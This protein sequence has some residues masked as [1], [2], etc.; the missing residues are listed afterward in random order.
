MPIQPLP[1]HKLRYI[2][3][4]AQFAFETTAELSPTS[5]IIGQPRGIRAIEFGIGIQSEGYNIY[6]LGPSG[7]GRATAIERFLRERSTQQPT[8]LDWVYV[9]NFTIP[10]QPRA[11]ELIAGE[12]AVFK[13]RM[14]QLIKNLREVL[15]QAFETEA[16]EKT[17][18]SLS[19]EIQ[20][21]QRELLD[22]LH[23]EALPHNFG[24]VQTASGFVMAPV[25]DG[26][27]LNSEEI[28]ELPLD[29]QHSID[30][31]AQDWQL[32]LNDILYQVHV[33]EEDGRQQIKE[34][35]RQVAEN[36]IQHYF[37]ELRT[38]YAEREEIL[39]YLG[40]VY[41]DVLN[42]IDDFAPA[43][44]SENPD[45]EIDLRRYEVN[46]LV[47]HSTSKGAPVVTEQ[48]PTYYNLIGRIEY[49]M[50]DSIVSTHFTNIKAGSLHRANGGYL[51]MNAQDLMRDTA[52][53]ETLKRALR[54]HEIRVQPSASMDGEQVLAKS[55][56]PEPIPL[57]IKIILTG[58]ASLYY[59]LYEQEEDFCDLFK[60][61]ADFDS[62]MNRDDQHIQE[63]AQFIATRCH[64]EKLRHF[65][66]AA[67]AKIVEFG[68]FMVAYQKKLT[69]RFGSIADLTREASYWAGVNGRSLVTAGDVQQAINERTY[70]AN[71]LEERI[72]EQILEGSVF[73]ATDGRVVGQVNGL[74]VIDLGDYYFGQ[75]G[76]VTART[77]MGD[78]GVVHIER[79]TE[80]SGPI[81]EKGVLTLTGYLGGKY[82]QHQ[83]L[84]LTASVTFEQNYVPVEGDSA[85]TTELYAL[86]S[87]L[88]GIPIKQ[89]IGVTG[90]VNQR[91]EVQPIGGVNEK[92]LGFFKVC[93]ARGLTG[94]QG[95]MIPASNIDNLMLEEEILAACAEGKFHV[96]AIAT[97]DEGLELLMDVPAGQMDEEGQYPEGTVHYSVQQRLWQLAK[98]LNDFGNEN[99][100]GNSEESE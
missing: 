22:T 74:T 95:V 33:L 90:S 13:S 18:E 91:G 66:R 53:W 42:Q 38:V 41:Q 78:D 71:S 68:S 27:P 93:Q 57:N 81:H 58:S 63:Y 79:E 2:C 24:L 70:R 1:P 26:R 73:I 50:I 19:K 82:A 4:P 64:E 16:Y 61:R 44:D 99:E 55:L 86:L 30:R 6:I 52:I 59:A 10:H 100:A 89:S 56:D 77:F 54:T 43:A 88:S 72:L 67:V 75:P 17:F 84:S 39:L 34:L 98:E 94:E 45:R 96:W 7:T 9:H 32:K 49:E 8:P 25:Q 37:D 36:A 76:R 62:V 46:L 15:P 3:D 47:D 14:A 83:P 12:G 29:E 20:D 51:I 65:D 97:V 31:E 92:I 60:V 40:E 23:Q 28:E 80:M 85:S 69:T 21:Q 87:S 5:M 35:D 11:I 48:N